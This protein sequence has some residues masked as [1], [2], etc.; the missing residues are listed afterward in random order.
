MKSI[1]IFGS[2][3]SSFFNVRR[4]NCLNYVKIHKVSLMLLNQMSASV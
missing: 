1:Q 3:G 2:V 4:W